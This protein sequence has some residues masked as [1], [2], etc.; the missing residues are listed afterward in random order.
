MG[1]AKTLKKIKKEIKKRYPEYKVL[2]KVTHD[3]N[4]MGVY[5][6]WNKHHQITASC[7]KTICILN[8]F[9]YIYLM[10]R[11]DHC[12]TLVEN[13][14]QIDYKRWI[15]VFFEST[16]L[17]PERPE[18]L[19]CFICQGAG[20]SLQCQ[21]CFNTVC[22]KC[23]AKFKTNQCPYCRRPNLIIP[24]TRPWYQCF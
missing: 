24:E 12:K 2:T 14:D 8:K 21:G 23:C 3:A 17:K 1:L 7:A 13:F 6:A 10:N 19:P 16:V 18:G 20:D 15:K 22:L 4:V 5:D 9:G 11:S